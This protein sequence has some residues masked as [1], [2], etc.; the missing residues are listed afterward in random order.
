MERRIEVGGPWFEDFKRGD[1][2]EETPALTLHAGHAALHQAL[3]GDRMRLPLDA[4][5]CARVTGR[6]RLLANPS[7]VSN[8]AIGQTTYASQRVRGNLFYRGLR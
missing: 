4:T 3:F 2:F 7:L 1:I 6:D 5:L 8:V